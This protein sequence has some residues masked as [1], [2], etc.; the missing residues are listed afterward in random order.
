MK[1]TIIILFFITTGNTMFGQ[2]KICLNRDFDLPNINI[3][4]DEYFQYLDSL[5]YRPRKYLCLVKVN[6][7]D[8]G[9]KDYIISV[10]MGKGIFQNFVKK[11]E[12]Y[13]KYKGRYIILVGN[14]RI[15]KSS[16][17]DWVKPLFAGDSSELL[18]H[19]YDERK[20]KVYFRTQPSLI[21]S[22]NGVEKYSYLLQLDEIPEDQSP[23]LI[24]EMYPW[25]FMDLPVDT[26]R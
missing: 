13:F 22:P 15:K 26:I 21:Y 3:A 25:L 23:F 1:K 14:Y 11:H 18:S 12:Y 5:N 10:V 20:I 9:K 16:N 7:S 6:K 8:N 19:L 17:G 24:R 2:S 4:L